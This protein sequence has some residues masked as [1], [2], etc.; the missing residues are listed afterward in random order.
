MLDVVYDVFVISPPF[1]GKCVKNTKT[2]EMAHPPFAPNPNTCQNLNVG[3]CPTKMLNMFY[4]V[5]VIS[6]P[7]VGKCLK[8]KS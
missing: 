5:F 8:P 3:R 1:V 7:F 2:F 6:P 4:D